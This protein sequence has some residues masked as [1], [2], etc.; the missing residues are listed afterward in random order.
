M[1]LPWLIGTVAV[2]AAGAL[3]KA[4]QDDDSSSSYSSSSEREDQEREANRQREK[5]RLDQQISNAEI[6]LENDLKSSLLNAWK[7]L[8]WGSDNSLHN[9]NLDFLINE[10]SQEKKSSIDYLNLNYSEENLASNPYLDKKLIDTTNQNLSTLE[11][12]GF[13]VEISKCDKKIIDDISKSLEHQ[14][15]LKALMK[16]IESINF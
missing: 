12:I 13:K 11:R 8:E 6:T 14:E 4:L 10:I 15:A 2:V 5:D 1:P 7:Y 16:K 9:K 3:Y